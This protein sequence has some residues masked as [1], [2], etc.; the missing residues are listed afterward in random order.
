MLIGSLLALHAAFSAA[1]TVSN[2]DDAPVRRVPKAVT[3]TDDDE[4]PVRRQVDEEDDG[5]EEDDV[6]DDEPLSLEET[7]ELSLSKLHKHWPRC[8]VLKEH[9][10]NGFS[11]HLKTMNVLPN[12]PSAQACGEKCGNFSYMHGGVSIPCA[13][14]AWVEKSWAKEFQ[15][16]KSCAMFGFMENDAGVTRKPVSELVFK[17]HC[18]IAGTPCVGHE[19]MSSY[20][21]KKDRV[22]ALWRKAERTRIKCEKMK[23][24]AA[25]TGKPVPK[26]CKVT[27]TG[28]PVTHAGKPGKSVN[29]V[30]TQ[31]GP[32]PSGMNLQVVFVIAAILA[33]GLI[34]GVCAW[35]TKG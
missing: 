7:E 34:V 26:V 2:G 13:T 25:A 12:V 15:G 28:K 23:R 22:G 31:A 10:W 21:A 6:D 3:E 16:H 32:N 30:S 9:N 11:H 24:I 8:Q 33:L 20:D 1:V 5:F 14:W 35:N 29:T 18:C 19:K 17:N 4:T 27:H